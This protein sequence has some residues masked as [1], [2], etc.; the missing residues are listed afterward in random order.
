M[1]LPETTAQGS[2]ALEVRPAAG[3]VRTAT[4]SGLGALAVG[5]LVELLSG[6]LAAAI[7]AGFF[8]GQGLTWIART[9]GRERRAAIA[10]NL[11]LAAML[12]GALTLAF[13]ADGVLRLL[14][15]I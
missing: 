11:L 3:V 15:L 13:N 1:T 10:I 14:G 6:N 7:V 8:V 12:G 9:S 2:T 5:L 4:R